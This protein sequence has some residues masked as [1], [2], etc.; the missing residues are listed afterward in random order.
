[1]KID[2]QETT[3]DLSTRIDIHNKYGG[4][5]IDRWML[6]LLKFKKE[7]ILDVGCGAGKQCFSYLNYLKEKAEI[8][9][10]DISADLLAQARKE[11]PRNW[12]RTRFI[13][14]NFN[15]RFPSRK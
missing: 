12:S 14:L 13:D 5:D 4:R 8:T 6:D 10:G 7:K 9:G 15:Q 1:M 2:Y 3:N 11:N